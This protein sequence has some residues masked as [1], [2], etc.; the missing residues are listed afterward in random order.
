MAAPSVQAAGEDGLGDAANLDEAVGAHG[1]VEDARAPH[2][3]ALADDERTGSA[4]AVGEVG[5]GRRGRSAR[6]LF[7][8][9]DRRA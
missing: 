5:D 7:E 2:V 8:V 1:G 6:R 3:F 4:V 9:P